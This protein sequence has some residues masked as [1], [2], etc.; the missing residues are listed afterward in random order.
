[1]GAYA[2]A[3]LEL[4]ALCVARCGLNETIQRRG[5]R[6]VDDE[7]EDDD[8]DE[9]DK[10][11]NESEEGRSLVA[12]EEHQDRRRQRQ[13]RRAE[14]E[15]EAAAL[16]SAL[17]NPWRQLRLFKFNSSNDASTPALRALL[18]PLLLTTAATSVH[19]IWYWYLTVKF[20]MDA[21]AIGFMLSFAGLIAAVTNGVF[22]KKL[23]PVSVR[24]LRL[25]F[26]MH[27]CS[28]IVSSL[29]YRFA[30]SQDYLGVRT[31]IPMGLFI[32]SFEYVLYALCSFGWGLVI[33]MAAC[34]LGGLEQPTTH[35]LM[36]AEVPVAKQGALHGA[37]T[38]ARTL[39]QVSEG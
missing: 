15:D 16:S 33:I 32:R 10:E 12:N 13:R 7:E 37:V 31:V 4:V 27:A 24:L 35:A 3:A 38:A 19:G 5:R 6:E 23:V 39:V 18:A 29:W 11:N 17:R 8:D 21:V 30:L 28:K 9:D 2:V 36:S 34:C 1:M 26:S 25:I 22:L 14:T 20:R